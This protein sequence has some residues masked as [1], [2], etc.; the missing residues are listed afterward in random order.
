MHTAPACQ[1]T[2]SLWSCLSNSHVTYGFWLPQILQ[3]YLF[4]TPLTWN[5]A[6]SEHTWQRKSGDASILS[7]M[8]TAKFVRA[9]WALSFRAWIIWILY[10][11]RQSL[12][13]RTS[14]TV[15]RDICNCKLGAQIFLRR[16]RWNASLMWLTFSSKI[17]VFAGDFTCDGLP[18]AL[19]L[20]S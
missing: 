7:S 20:L 18:G 8:S 19:S 3:L 9:T 14:C 16:L 17:H 6:S 15:E 1:P 4:T 12:L 13:C 2:C 11:L 5:T 10:A